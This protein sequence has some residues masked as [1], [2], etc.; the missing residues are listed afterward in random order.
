MG[1]G[2]GSGQRPQGCSCPGERRAAA[3]S[4]V[5]PGRVGRPGC[6]CGRCFCLLSLYYFFFFAFFLRERGGGG[7]K[8]SGRRAHFLQVDVGMRG[9]EL[10][11]GTAAP[12][13]A[14]PPFLLQLRCRQQKP[15]A[16]GS[17]PPTEAEA[18][19][20]LRVPRAVHRGSGS[21]QQSGDGGAV[22]NQQPP[23]QGLL[24]PQVKLCRAPT[25]KEAAPVAPRRLSLAF[26]FCWR[27]PGGR[28]SPPGSR[29]GM[30][31]GC[32]RSP[33]PQPVA[34]PIPPPAPLWG[35]KPP[36][37][38]PSHVGGAAAALCS[39]AGC[40]GLLLLREEGEKRRGGSPPGDEEVG[41][42]VLP[43]AF[44]PHAWE[45]AAGAKGGKL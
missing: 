38:C 41:R 2:A 6:V 37:V 14:S 10:G 12:G 21:A 9:S 7:N 13:R 5:L 31:P 33:Q 32:S 11:S 4:G 1:A 39:G 8:R 18:G 45:K 34:V 3:G 15:S 16:L 29:P 19:R 40:A 25:G 23:P 35:T 36:E 27:M 43:E 22:H 24:L 44:G 30:G 26:G 20:R 17:L 28:E 42:G